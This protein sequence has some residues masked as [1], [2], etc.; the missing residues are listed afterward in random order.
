MGASDREVG[1]R[2][3]DLGEGAGE[4]EAVRIDEERAVARSE[5]S[6]A[7]GGHD[8]LPASGE[9]IEVDGDGGLVG[10]GSAFSTVARYIGAEAGSRG[11]IAVRRYLLRSIR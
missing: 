9:P 10:H 6:D 11:G 1:A 8:H 3:A 7:G 4:L 5:T 2:V